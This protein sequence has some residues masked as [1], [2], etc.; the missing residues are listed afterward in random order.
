MALR[1]VSR[2]HPLETVSSSKQALNLTSWRKEIDFMRQR[3]EG[4]K[5]R[6]VVSR[7]DD[8]CVEAL[9]TEIEFFQ[10]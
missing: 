7:R 1:Q 9:Y 3:I 2:E 4:M 6:R 8:G 5:E 10:A